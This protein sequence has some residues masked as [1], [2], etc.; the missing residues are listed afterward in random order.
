VIPVSR[1]KKTCPQCRSIVT[2]R[3][4][5][6]FLIRDFAH[7]VETMLSAHE[8]RSPA[9]PQQE[10]NTGADPWE[11]V[12]PAFT[13]GA[14]DGAIIDHEDGGV[15]RCPVCTWEIFGAICEGCGR[16]F[17]EDDGEFD[18]DDEQF[19]IDHT[20]EY[21]WHGNLLPPP[22]H[23][24]YARTDDYDEDEY[25]TP[26]EYGNEDEYEGSFISD[27]EQ[28]E[29]SRRWV[30]DLLYLDDVLSSTCSSTP[31][32]ETYEDAQ[33]EHWHS[34]SQ[35]SDDSG[36]SNQSRQQSVE[37]ADESPCLGLNTDA[38]DW[39]NPSDSEDD[40]QV[41]LRAPQGGHRQVIYSDNEDEHSAHVSLS[42]LSC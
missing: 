41:F 32:I 7:H 2:Q 13:G 40:H 36:N 39:V 42:S 23:V 6:I 20:P 18:E 35:H 4:V 5:G 24:F 10:A 1:R 33:S 21:D 14:A 15:R 30:F 17:D 19:F 29:G 3:P 25:D 8:G 11:G 16:E 26:G 31:A 38:E 9:V 22:P 34:P 28:E 37:L 12:F 27:E